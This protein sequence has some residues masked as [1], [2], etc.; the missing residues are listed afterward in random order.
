MTSNTKISILN[1]IRPEN[2]P[3]FWIFLYWILPGHYT[4]EGLLISQFNNDETPIVA[5][6]NSP[7][8]NAIDCPKQLQGGATECVGTASEWVQASFG[9]IYKSEDI[10]WN[11]L[12]LCCLIIVTRIVTGVA[13][14]TINFRRT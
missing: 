10:P 5:S 1:S 13:L 4:Y 11:I 12:Y 3:P 8:W 2:I 9:G 7:F 14:A 6:P